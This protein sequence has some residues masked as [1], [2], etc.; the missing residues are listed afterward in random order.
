MDTIWWVIK[1]FQ[2]PCRTAAELMEVG[3][4]ELFDPGHQRLSE[5]QEIHRLPQTQPAPVH[6]INMQDRKPLAFPIRKVTRVLK[7]GHE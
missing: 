3:P 5:C 1:D 7:E 4:G 6:S 2:S